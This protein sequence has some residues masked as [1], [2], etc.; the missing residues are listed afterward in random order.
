MCKENTIL[1]KTAILDLKMTMGTVDK[2]N[3]CSLRK[4][5]LKSQRP[6]A[7]PH[8]KFQMICFGKI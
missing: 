8:A 1:T 4:Y 2:S 6:V 3:V 5:A 7:Y